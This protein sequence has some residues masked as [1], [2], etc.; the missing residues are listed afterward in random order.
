MRLYKCL[1]CG[2]TFNKRMSNK[3]IQDGHCKMFDTTFNTNWN[4]FNLFL[5]FIELL[6]DLIKDNFRYT[7]AFVLR[8]RPFDNVWGHDI[9][10][11]KSLLW[12]IKWLI[13]CTIYVD[14]HMIKQYKNFQHIDR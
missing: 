12:N 11:K 4:R 7:K 5:E 13:H 1:I 6:I 3:G 14:Y 2:D 8:K 10:D 9:N